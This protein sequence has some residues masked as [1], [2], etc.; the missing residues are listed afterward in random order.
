MLCQESL[1]KSRGRNPR[2]SLSRVEPQ[3]GLAVGFV[4]QK[5]LPLENS[6]FRKIRR[7]F[8]FSRKSVEIWLRS[9][10]PRRSQMTTRLTPNSNIR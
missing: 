3:F 4:S 6:L 10:K 9:A 2:S 1:S 5:R 7:F 8:A